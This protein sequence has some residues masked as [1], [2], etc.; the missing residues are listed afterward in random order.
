MHC[1][2]KHF[3]AAVTHTC[4]TLKMGTAI[5]GRRGVGKVEIET[6]E[7]GPWLKEMIPVLLLSIV[8]NEQYQLS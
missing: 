5:I 2:L 4:G 7:A 8:D 6:T 3:T 1:R